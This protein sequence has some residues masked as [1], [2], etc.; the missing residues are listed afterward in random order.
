[1]ALHRLKG[2]CG[3][4]ILSRGFMD[5]Y[6][7]TWKDCRIALVTLGL[8]TLWATAAVL[9]HPNKIDH[10]YGY[11]AVTTQF[12]QDAYARD[13]IMFFANELP[14]HPRITVDL[15]N[16]TELAQSYHIKNIP[17]IEFNPEYNKSDVQ[18]EITLLHEACHISLPSGEG[19][20]SRWLACMHRLATEGAMDNLW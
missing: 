15:T 11:P 2:R 18:A 12:L 9:I 19:H 6:N 14:Q 17:V 16:E 8:I 5:E 7:I 3:A 10:K 1:M 4:I 13:N 20:S